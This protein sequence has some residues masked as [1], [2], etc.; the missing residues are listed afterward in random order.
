M[1]VIT[2]PGE[3]VGARSLAAWAEAWWGWALASPAAAS[4][5]VDATGER[6]VDGQPSGVFFLAGATGGAVSRTCSVPG[7]TPIVFPVLNNISPDGGVAEC[8]GQLEP[9]TV[10]A[11]LDGVPIGELTLA[12]GSVTVD[13]APGNWAELDP[14]P[15]EASVAGYWVGIVDLSP[16][17]H[18]VA[19]GGSAEGLSVSVRY[20]LTVA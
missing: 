17:H 6:A 14:G 11:A 16:G 1:Q 2:D 19:F 5:V 9:A 10:R 3:L 20:D 8:L 12:A 13:P 18:V 4:A 7:G 15:A